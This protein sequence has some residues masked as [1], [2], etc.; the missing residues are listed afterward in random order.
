MTGTKPVQVHDNESKDDDAKDTALVEYRRLTS[1]STDGE[2]SINGRLEFVEKLFFT[3]YP[4]IEPIDSIRTFTNEQR[5]AVFRRGAGVCQ[6]KTHCS[7]ERLMWGDWHA[8]H[9]VPYSRGG[10]T[11]VSNGQIACPACNLAKS[12]RVGS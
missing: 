6:I 12:N 8:D 1:Y 11:T 5:L 3:A 10:K 2:D 7:G 4:D 9:I